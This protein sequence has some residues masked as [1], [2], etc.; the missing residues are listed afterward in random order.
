MHNITRFV[1]VIATLTT[2]GAC[3]SKVTGNEGNFQFSYPAD[4]DVF[5]FNKPIAV[6]ARLD[7]TVEQQDVA[8]TLQAVESDDPSVEVV[9]FEGS[10]FTVE[11]KAEGNVLISVEGKID[12][13]V[14][15]DS[16]NLTARIPDNHGLAHTCGADGQT[17][18][19]AGQKSYVAFDMTMENGQNVIGYGYYPVTITGG[20]TLDSTHQG[21]QYFRI[22]ATTAGSF[23]ID[24]DLDG[25]EL[26]LTIVE[27][28]DIDGAAQPIAF[29]LED[30]D[31]GDTNAFYVLPRVGTR[32]VCQAIVDMVVTSDTPTIC[33]VRNSNRLAAESTDAGKESGWFEV[34]GVAEGTCEY[35][36]SY[37][38]SG[39]SA[40]FSFPIEP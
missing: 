5:D 22:D 33:T 34:T 6:G 17:A 1:A 25:T 39:A 37:P 30:I 29:V 28:A 13:K 18:Y 32:T 40:Q 12:D 21:S 9:D 16:V 26:D 4:D 24:S 10:A 11:A 35:T 3:E 15:T 23:E 27:E 8:V 19:L 14:L 2:V 36:V 38:T 20:A 31:V 7:I